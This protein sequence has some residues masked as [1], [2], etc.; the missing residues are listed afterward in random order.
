M[1][2]TIQSGERN[3]ILKVIEFFENEKKNK[4][5]VL[6]VH[7][8]F[9]RACLATGCS[10]RTLSRIK[11][12]AAEERASLKTLSA[13]GTENGVVAVDNSLCAV[14]LSTPGKKRKPS[15]RKIKL[16]G[17]GLCK[18]RNIINSFYI[19]KREAP[20]MKKIFAAAKTDIN[21]PGGIDTLRKIIRD[22]LGY[23][24]KRFKN[25]RVSITQKP[26]ITAWRDRYLRCLNNNDDLDTDRR[27]VTYLDETWIHSH[28][29]TRQTN[30]DNTQRWI[31]VHAG[32][33]SGL[34]AGAGLLYRSKSGEY[35]DEVD[36]ERFTEWLNER[37][38]PNLPKHSIVI[39]NNIPYYYKH[40]E[41]APARGATKDEIK[42]WLQQHNISF[43]E[44]MTNRELFNLVVKN[45]SHKKCIAEELLRGHG[46]EVMLLPPH[47][48]DL[49]PLEYIWNLVKQRVAEGG[50]QQSEGEAEQLIRDAITSITADDWRRHMSHVNKLRRE[51][52]ENDR[53]QEVNE[54]MLISQLGCESSSGGD[55][56]SDTCT[57]TS[58]SEVHTSGVEA[59]FVETCYEMGP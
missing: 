59:L 46:H 33:E 21:F 36:V 39:I 50:V 53:I 29:I 13:L 7:Q 22:Q 52:W 2:R 43:E 17:F 56:D 38:I 18:L 8:A 32:G 37:L 23:K 44:E 11:R 24:F 48:C 49:N 55:S 30:V 28:G 26:D 58:D 54:P 45:R 19:V 27:P 4:Q 3:I 25:T 5:F 20:T 15:S 47:H 35:H 57:E 40:S 41:R 12:E 1:G 6:P 34:V 10:K 9:K 14:K 42:T 31:V 51:Y 16:N